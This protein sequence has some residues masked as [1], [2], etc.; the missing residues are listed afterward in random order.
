[1]IPKA[2]KGD[3]I[4]IIYQSDYTNKVKDFLENNNCTS[5]TKYPTN[6][7][8]KEVRNNVNQCQLLIPKK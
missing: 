8:Q 5:I 4:V 3:F 7:F 1:M 2:D 6:M